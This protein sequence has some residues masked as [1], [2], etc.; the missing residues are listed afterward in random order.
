MDHHKGVLMKYFL[1]LLPFLSIYFFII[2][3]KM[4]LKKLNYKSLNKLT[5]L[6]LILISILLIC[7]IIL[8]IKIPDIIYIINMTIFHKIIVVLGLIQVSIMIYS[9]IKY[10]IKKSLK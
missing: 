4:Y 3:S 8:L 9:M 2:L 1:F 6:N 5:I 10:Y 7:E